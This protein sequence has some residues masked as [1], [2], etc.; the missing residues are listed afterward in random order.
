MNDGLCDRRHL[1][2]AQTYSREWERLGNLLNACSYEL[3]IL[4]A[5]TL[6]VIGAIIW[7]T[8]SRRRREFEYD[9]PPR[10]FKELCRAH[11]LTWS[12]RRL[13][14]QLAAARGLKGAALLF[15]EPEH[16]DVTNIP[17]ALKA[18]A[19]ELRRLRHKLFD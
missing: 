12:N 17:A 11:K 1:I 16:F 4:A 19:A 6:L 2:A 9:R 15:V 7:Q 14:I 8:I 3:L 10:L 13:L 18:S 5:V